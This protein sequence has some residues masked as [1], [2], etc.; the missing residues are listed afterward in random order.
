MSAVKR[1]KPSHPEDMKNDGSWQTERASTAHLRKPHIFPPP[2][3]SRM[4]IKSYN[5]TGQ[6]G[7]KLT[8]GMLEPRLKQPPYDINHSGD[9]FTSENL[10]SD[11]MSDFNCNNTSTTFINEAA[12]IHQVEHVNI[13][14]SI[15]TYR[16]QIPSMPSIG[17]SQRI[18]T[19]YEAVPHAN[20]GDFASSAKS[21]FFFAECSSESEVEDEGEHQNIMQT[22]ISVR[23]TRKPRS[24]R[25]RIPIRIGSQVGRRSQPSRNSRC[26][27]SI[28][29]SIVNSSALD[30]GKNGWE[31]SRTLCQRLAYGMQ[32]WT[33]SILSLFLFT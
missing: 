28:E 21:G 15:T 8:S 9:L 2:P 7:D 29:V 3:P 11:F 19:D 5:N 24:T 27:K 18:I 17:K 26:Q 14:A 31:K 1:S 16:S 25:S 30:S 20:N 12:D 13:E 33:P 23:N 22:G 32:I 10:K 4:A 6:S